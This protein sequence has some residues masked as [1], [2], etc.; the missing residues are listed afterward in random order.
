ML[1]EPQFRQMAR[2]KGN[3]DIFEFVI[4]SSWAVHFDL[5]ILDFDLDF[6]LRLWT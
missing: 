6:R 4:S 5:N 3:R 2:A 1:L